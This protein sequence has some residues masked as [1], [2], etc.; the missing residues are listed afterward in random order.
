MPRG[1]ALYK[2][3]NYKKFY[4]EL[5]SVIHNYTAK[6]NGIKKLVRELSYKPYLVSLS[7]DYYLK[8]TLKAIEKN[9]EDKIKEYGTKFANRFRET[10]TLDLLTAIGAAKEIPYVKS[11]EKIERMTKSLE[12]KLEYLQDSEATKKIEKIEKILEKYTDNPNVKNAV[13][14]IYLGSFARDREGK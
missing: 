4:D 5:Y 7:K 12:S 3:T 6:Y 8:K 10:E 14:N 13:D 1:Y 9:E 2:N 11:I